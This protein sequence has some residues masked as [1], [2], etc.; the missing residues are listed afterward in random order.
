MIKLNQFALLTLL[1]FLS[2]NGKNYI[3]AQDEQ[4]NNQLNELKQVALN[5]I[6][7][8]FKLQN[9]VT[10]N[11][12]N[13]KV[14]WL[15]RTFSLKDNILEIKEDKRKTDINGKLIYNAERKWSID[16]S[17]IESIDIVKCPIKL[18]CLEVV[19]TP[20][21][22]IY[23]SAPYQDST[24]Y[25][26]NYDGY[27]NGARIFLKN[28]D[29]LS[30]EILKKIN[31][32]TSLIKRE[33]KDINNYE[34]FYLM[35]RQNPKGNLIYFCEKFDA[36][37]GEVN[38]NNEFNTGSLTLVFN[39][40]KPINTKK[41][42]IS[43]NK[44]IN[45]NIEYKTKIDSK[46]NSNSVARDVK[47][48]NDNNNVLKDFY[49]IGK[50]ANIIQVKTIT[51]NVDPKSTYIY[52]N[53]D[54]KHDLCFDESGQYYINIWSVDE[55][56]FLAYNTINIVGEPLTLNAVKHFTFA[57]HNFTPRK[58]NYFDKLQE[59]KLI[60]EINEGF[61]PSDANKGIQKS[62]SVNLI[63]LYGRLGYLYLENLDID[64]A[65]VAFMMPF[66]MGFRDDLTMKL[67]EIFPDI[68]FTISGMEL[69]GITIGKENEFD[70][71]RAFENAI[72]EDKNTEYLEKSIQDAQTAISIL[73]YLLKQPN[74]PDKWQKEY[75][76]NTDEINYKIKESADDLNYVLKLQNQTNAAIFSSIS[77]IAK[78]FV[79]PNNTL[80]TLSYLKSGFNQNNSN[81]NFADFVSVIS[82]KL[83]TSYSSNKQMNFTNFLSILNESIE[84]Q[85][86]L[87]KNQNYNSNNANLGNQFLSYLESALN[88]TNP[89][90][91]SN[92]DN[93]FSLNNFS[94]ELGTN[95]S[96]ININC[97]LCTGEAG[98]LQ[99]V[100]QA[101]HGNLKANYLAAA[102]ITSCYINNNCYNDAN[103]L[104]Q[105]IRLRD[106]NLEEANKLNDNKI[107]DIRIPDV[108][109]P[110]Y[111]TVSNSHYNN[112][113]PCKGRYP[114]AGSA[115]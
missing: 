46:I 38:I 3:F 15:N 40:N 58:L 88:G 11:G 65:V 103:E 45:L 77:E 81:F 109:T 12:E 16:L 90:N 71:H 39:S 100:Y 29:D 50:D 67:T 13:E 98:Y 112:Y 74:I 22:F 34:L 25:D 89:L 9:D 49:G 108:K 8:L 43:I 26:I 31:F 92:F 66:N 53:E 47:E 72:F 82:A 78:T 105:L 99:L 63:K 91:N 35:E 115:Y 2:L 102:Y 1:F 24:K 44:L 36:A 83:S 56:R 51:Y 96:L 48:K 57:V 30:S 23:L 94:S 10:Y 85:S 37:T 107:T 86:N 79:T 54:Y 75:K 55:K 28:D 6:D 70:F 62:D 106:K 64:K 87:L 68:Y 17:R 93:P 52:F 110:K 101:K 111:K 113:D 4:S 76:I 32:L 21:N 80:N 104:A 97:A 19:T 59:R 18:N 20:Y 41:I 69:Q 73:N 5:K 14:V 42:I 33:Y 61:I 114:C 95:N 7:S 84:Q 27:I 60:K